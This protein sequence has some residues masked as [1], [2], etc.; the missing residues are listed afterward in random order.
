[1]ALRR[2][3]GSIHAAL[4]QS[5]RFSSLSAAAVISLLLCACSGG[6]G[7]SGSDSLTASGVAAVATPP[8]SAITNGS[9]LTLAMVGPAAIGVNVSQTSS[10]TE[11]ND[12]GAYPFATQVTSSAT[13]DGWTVS[14]PHL[15]IQGVAFPNGLN[16]YT[17]QT[18]VVRGSTFRGANA[19]SNFYVRPGAGQV[20]VLYCDAGAA[21]GAGAPGNNANE[22]NAAYSDANG[23]AIFYRNHGSMSRIAIQPGAGGL[24]VENYFDNWVYYTGDHSD[25]IM[26]D[27]AVDHDIQI[28][29]NKVLVNLDQTCA[30]CLFVD[31]GNVSNI[32]ADSNYLAGG[33]YAIYGGGTGSSFGAPSGIRI[34]NNVIGKDFYLTGGYWGFLAYW[35]GTVG[36]GNVWSN[37]SY[38]DGTALIDYPNNFPA[39]PIPSD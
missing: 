22:S 6:G 8:P 15:L 21:S 25:G 23:G 2:V 11:I 24:V 14:G 37:N 30:L 31:F 19:A 7:P 1:M 5:G 32:A 39:G 4:A 13:Y 18:V 12:G 38:S 26:I 35:P 36:S 9:Q 16:I 20:Y 29:R 10:E 28:L 34:T 27:N 3:L 33:G 17:K